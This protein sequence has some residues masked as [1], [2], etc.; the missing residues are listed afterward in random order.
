VAVVTPHGLGMLAESQQQLGGLR[1]LAYG[2]RPSLLFP[3][4]TVYLLLVG[5]SIVPRLMPVALF[6][7]LAVLTITLW[8]IWR[9]CRQQGGGPR[10]LI[11][12]LLVAGITLLGPFGLGLIHPFFLPERTLL[13]MLPAL[14]VLIAWGMAGL[15]RRTPLPIMGVG[16]VLIMLLSQWGYY[17]NP[18][19]Q[20]PPM[21]EAAAFIQQRFVSGDVVLHTSDGSYLPFLV[22]PHQAEG[23]LLRGDPDAR[24]PDHV[25]RV[26]GGQTISREEALVQ[27]RRVWL[28]V[29]LEHSFDYQRETLAW[30]QTRRPVVEEYDVEGIQVYLLDRFAP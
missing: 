24:K 27:D 9:V 6:S 2:G 8:E 21:R 28:V 26:L 23:Y 30:F 1:P 16:L 25:Y 4:T 12:L 3:L 11:L 22:Y 19:F 5:Y 29:A 17:F 7:S 14:A 15:G 18:D 10:P 20:K 13:M